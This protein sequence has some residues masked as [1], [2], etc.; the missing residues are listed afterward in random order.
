[1]MK[2]KMRGIIIFVGLIAIFFSSLLLVYTIP[3]SAVE[4]NIEKSS[5]VFE[6]EGNY[7]VLNFGD[8]S[9]SQLDN[10]TDSL[11]IKG[12]SKGNKG[13]VYESMD[14]SD[15]PRYWHGYLIFLRPLLV[16]FSYGSIRQ[17]YGLVLAVLIG[18]N[19]LLLAK[20]LNIFFA[21]SFLVTLFMAR[22]YT[23]FVS[24]QFS[25]VFIILMLCNIFLLTRKEKYFSNYGNI[26]ITCL[27]I[28]M[29]TNFF[30]LL[31]VPLITLAEPLILYLCLKNKY[32]AHTD[33]FT[34]ALE[35]VTNS[36]VWMVG[37][38]VTW[39]SK[40]IL[41]SFILKRNI[42][43][44]SLHR[45]LFRT[46]GSAD[47]PIDRAFMLKGNTSNFFSNFNIVILLL[48][49]LA[50][51]IYF[52]KTKHMPFSK[53][54]WP[55]LLLIAYPYIWYMIVVNHSQIHSFFTYRLQIISVFSLLPF[56][57]MQFVTVKKIR[58]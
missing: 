48:L 52:I 56:I 54:M 20:K 22:F 46:E 23:F 42:I 37:Y 47:Y 34:N 51:I 49:V 38:T 15:Y 13:V 27:S 10:F 50:A 4:K 21:F 39:F 43:K 14:N 45:I 8:K 1:M 5:V 41:A 28:G 40:W 44:E 29:I 36:I 57:S 33:F 7:P 26:L 6:A 17:L 53:K 55:I 30:D 32:I 31:T 25:N 2:N 35:I 18:L 3:N 9:A 24:M 16:F 11:M 12:A 19:C 58:R